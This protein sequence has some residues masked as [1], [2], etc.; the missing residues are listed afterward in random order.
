M[1]SKKTVLDPMDVVRSG[2]GRLGC[3]FW[4]TLRVDCFCSFI[5]PDWK[6]FK[7]KTIAIEPQ[8]TPVSS[9][10]LESLIRQF[11][12]LL[13]PTS[14]FGSCTLRR[15]VDMGDLDVRSLVIYDDY[16]DPADFCRA[17]LNLLTQAF[18]W[19]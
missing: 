15:S 16:E 5:Q 11:G 12:R 14:I 1:L 13:W 8:E 4:V 3:S 7:T 18:G 6:P 10:H 9:C 17:F 19:L 2:V